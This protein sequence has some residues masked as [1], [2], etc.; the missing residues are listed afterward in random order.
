[1]LQI[2]D[3]FSDTRRRFEQRA[4]EGEERLKNGKEF[5]GNTRK[6]CLRLSERASWLVNDCKTEKWL[7][8]P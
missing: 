3:P 4:G 2:D 8:N 7:Q 1:M 5:I 6:I